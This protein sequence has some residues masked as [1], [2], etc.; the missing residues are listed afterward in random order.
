MTAPRRIL[1][2]GA[3]GFVGRHLMRTLRVEFP[4]ATLIAAQRAVVDGP[5]GEADETLPFDLLAPIEMEGVIACARPDAVLHLAAQASVAASFREPSLSWRAN[6]LGTVALAEAVLRAAPEA[7]FLLAS[8]AEVFGLSFQVGLPLNEDAAL[9]PANPYAAAKAAADLAVGEMALRGLRAVR[10]RPFNHIGPGQSEDFVV[11]SFAAQLARIACGAQAPVMR[12]GVLDRWRD[13]LDV[14][15]V[16]RA[17]ALTLRADLPPGTALNLCSGTSRRIGDVLEA[18]VARAGVRP[19]IDTDADRL[20]PTDVEFVAG[21]ARRARE[22]LGW[23]PC[24]PWDRT[25][26]DVMEAAR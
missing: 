14:R 16:C 24:I 22:V 26:D 3:G 4:G 15:D 19:R 8:S 12:V 7:L 2:T 17:Y 1:V 23:S 9:R 18:L 25:M 20:R 13:F 6:L 10:M 21:D 11:A 5:P